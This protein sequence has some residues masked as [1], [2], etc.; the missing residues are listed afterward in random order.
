MYVSVKASKNILTISTSSTDWRSVSFILPDRLN[1]FERENTSPKEV[2]ENIVH[3]IRLWAQISCQTKAHITKGI[4][5]ELIAIIRGFHMS[6][7]SQVI[8]ISSQARNIRYTSQKSAK[9]LMMSLSRGIT[10]NN[11]FQKNI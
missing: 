5:T 6:L 11:D 9:K 1:S 4:N 2:V 10:S 7:V 3:I 8:L